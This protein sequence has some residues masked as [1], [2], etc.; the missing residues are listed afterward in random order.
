MGH[1]LAGLLE[2]FLANRSP[3]F[4]PRYLGVTFIAA[5]AVD[6]ADSSRFVNNFTND[7]NGTQYI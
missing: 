1:L 5:I 3:W 7:D 2:F 6:M 4:D